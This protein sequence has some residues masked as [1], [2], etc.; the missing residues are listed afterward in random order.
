MH[1]NGITLPTFVEGADDW[2]DAAACADLPIE[3]FFVQAGHIIDEEVLNVCRG[4]P[5]RVDCIVHSYNEDLNVTG[6]YFGGLS[7][8]QRREFT[9]EEA[10]E[11]AKADTPDTPRRV[12][13]EY[14]I[15]DDP[16]VYS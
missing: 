2:L 11:F 8:G 14:D 12:E 7:P 15:D 5:V 13:P 16:I 1:E 9:L 6:G 4:C 10:L 3:A